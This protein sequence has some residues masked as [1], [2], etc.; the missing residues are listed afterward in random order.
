MLVVLFFSVKYIE[1]VPKSD[2]NKN[3]S[4]IMAHLN[5]S[6]IRFITKRQMQCQLAVTKILI[7]TIKWTYFIIKKIDKFVKVKL[8]NALTKFFKIKMETIIKL[9]KFKQK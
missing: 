7:I 6:F 4:F 8:K 1:T 9:F 3:A 5:K 2:D